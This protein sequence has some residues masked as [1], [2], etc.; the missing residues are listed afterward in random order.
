MVSNI[1]LLYIHKSLSETFGCLESQPFPDLL[2]LVVGDL[3]QMLPVK[4]LQIFDP[5]QYHQSR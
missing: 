2:I 3:L 1:C 4:T 5:S